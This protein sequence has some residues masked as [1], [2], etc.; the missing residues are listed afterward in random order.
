MDSIDMQNA[1]LT[2]ETSKPGKLPLEFDIAHVQLTH[3]SMAGP[4]HF[5]AQLTNPKPSGN[6]RHFR[7]H[8]TVG[9][10]GSGR[11][12]GQRATTPLKTRTSASSKELREF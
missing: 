4:M 6:D 8:G 1:H 5:D 9:G 10:R 2:L 3:V 12:S 7:Q 11:D